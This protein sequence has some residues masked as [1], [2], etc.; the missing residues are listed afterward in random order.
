MND[1]PRQKLCELIAKYGESLCDEPLRC[2]GLLRDLCPKDRGTV[3]LLVNALREGVATEL[4]NHSVSV[5]IELTLSRLTKRLQ[6]HLMLSQEVSRWAVETWALALGKTPEA[7]LTKNPETAI[8]KP[9]AAV[10]HQPIQ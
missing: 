8:P 4:R 6:E 2:E 9:V 10:S 3:N 7:D 1:L 5:P